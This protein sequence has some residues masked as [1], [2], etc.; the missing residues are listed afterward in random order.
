M[1]QL[2]LVFF[3]VCF[4]IV[5][6]SI[7][8]IV[9]MPIYLVI[10][11]S[12]TTLF[13]LNKKKQIFIDFFN[14][15]NIAKMWNFHGKIWHSYE[16]TGMENIPKDTSA[17][18][19][20]YHGAIPVDLYYLISKI[21]LERKKLVYMVADNFLFK[22]PYWNLYSDQL[23][24]LTGTVEKCSELLS[25]KNNI[26][27]I[28]PGGLFEAQFST[29]YEILWRERYGFAKVAINSKTPII[30]VFT[31][32]IRE[33]FRCLYICERIKYFFLN[34]YISKRMPI[35]PIY[36]GFPVKLK[37]H[38]GK[39]IYFEENTTPEHLQKIV[40]L[41]LKNLINKHQKL[42]GNIFRSINERF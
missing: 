15:E 26:L 20:Y 28:S 4:D 3:L 12:I 24:I 37:T 32:N 17:L 34:L 40:G 31:E 42:P 25:D 41:E 33:V 18:L 36:G 16:I 19:V 8:F 6:T 39:P 29:D 9:L 35:V 22:I 2:I 27:A 30:P 11:F 5:K 21:Y 14:V 13:L 38:I 23:Q 1:L 10:L 7:F